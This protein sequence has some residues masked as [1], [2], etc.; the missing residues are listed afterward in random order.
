MRKVLCILLVVVA[1]LSLS[2]VSFAEYKGKVTFEVNLKDAAKAEKAELWL[3]YP[4]S[5]ANQT[6]SMMDIK[7]NG[8]VVGVENDPKS[9][10]VYLHATWTKPAEVP[11]LMMSF[12]ADSHY[13]K[14]PAAA[15]KETKD[16][17]PPEV[18]KYT[19]ATPS[20]PID[21]GFCAEASME[22]LK[23]ET[24]LDK[25]MGIYM[26]VLE[27]TFRDEDVKEGCGLGL[28]ERTISEKSGGGKCADISSVF[29]ALARASGIPTRDV[30]GLR[31]DPAKSGEITGN[32]HCWTEFYLPGTG[33]VMADP[34][35]VRKKMLNENI[36]KVE[37]AKKWVDF[38]WAGDDLLRIALN[39]DT[40]ETVLSETTAK[41]PLTYFMYPYA[42]IDGKAVDWF[43]P[44]TFE[45]KVTLDLE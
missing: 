44:K 1:V 15:L 3:P 19:M 40:R 36:E 31:V 29:V 41:T 30:Y 33:W 34:A 22:F 35:D 24:V 17:F 43:S 25:A 39:R 5:D 8:A 6:I 2:A 42:E 10:A 37:D 45:F 28:P 21:R 11:C 4:L 12:K 32:Y 9:G 18:M 23:K 7:S 14:K 13:S 20:L 38:F 26:W 16:A 27:H